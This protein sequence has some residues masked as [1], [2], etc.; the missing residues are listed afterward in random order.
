MHIMDRQTFTDLLYNHQT[1]P[2]PNVKHEG[3][4]SLHDSLL[5]AP[6]W[7][8]WSGNPHRV[9]FCSETCLN[10]RSMESYSWI[11]VIWK[12]LPTI[13]IHK[14][15]Y[16]SIALKLNDA[17]RTT[18]Q[19]NFLQFIY[20]FK[21]NETFHKTIYIYEYIFYEWMTV[22]KWKRKEE[23]VGQQLTSKGGFFE[24]NVF[25]SRWLWMGKSIIFLLSTTLNFQVYHFHMDGIL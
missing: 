1:K 13:Y 9:R 17:S 18:N 2:T 25:L 21:F 11:L 22:I 23:R 7:V 15:N 8:I 14:I 12:P 3:L 19:S 20:K 6:K 4:N 24:K 10:H 16:F 5:P